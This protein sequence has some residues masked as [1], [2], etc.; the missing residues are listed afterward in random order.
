[1]RILVNQAVSSLFGSFAGA[2]SGGGAASGLFGQLFGML[3]KGATGGRVSSSGIG[4]NAVMHFAGGGRTKGGS[5]KRDDI[6]AMLMGDEF[7]INQF[8]SRKLGYAALDYINK[9]GMLPP[10]RAE[11]GYVNPPSMKAPSYAGASSA[12]SIE[13]NITIHIDQKG[14]ASTQSNNNDKMAQNMAKAIKA[15]VK[16][17]ITESMRQGGSL[18]GSRR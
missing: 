13:N 11:G 6:P 18:S 14:N 15:A 17:E 2:T 1:V 10:Q 4:D 8:A 5:Y 9:T 16:E 3:A 12:A 7:V